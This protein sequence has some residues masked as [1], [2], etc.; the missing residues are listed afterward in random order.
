M[1][2]TPWVVAV[3]DSRRV[4]LTG[5]LWL[6]GAVLAGV[7]AWV[8]SLGASQAW[9]ASGA[10]FTAQT[11]GGPLVLPDGR[12]WEMVSPPEKGN[13]LI[14]GI[15]GFPGSTNGGLLQAAASGEAIVYASNGGFADSAGLPLE[16]QYLATRGVSGWSTVSITPRISSESYSPV[17]QGGPYK[18]FSSNLSSG[19]LLNGDLRPVRNPP[20]GGA[21]E[22]YQ[23]LYVQDIGTGDFHAVLTS[24]NPPSEPPEAFGLE[25]VGATPDLSHIVFST[26]AALTPNAIDSGS[27]NLYEWSNGQLQLVNV[28]PGAVLGE[29]LANSPGGLHPISNDGSV[30]FFSYEGDLYAHEN[31]KSGIQVDASSEGPESGGGQFQTAS[32]DGSRVF[33]TDRSRLTGNSTANRGEGFSDLYELDLG[34]GQLSDLTVGDPAGADVQRVLGAS[35]DGSYVYFVANGVLAQGASRGH[36]RVNIQGGGL[37]TCSLYVWHRDGG[38]GTTK[39]IATLSEDDNKEVSLDNAE[40]SGVAD[41][42]APSVANRTSRVTSDGLGLVFMSDGRLTGYDN[43]NPET[44]GR[45]QEVYVY[46]AGANAGAGALSCASCDPSGAQPSG[47]S[48]IPGGTQFKDVEAIYQSRVLSGVGGR[49]RVFFNSADALVPRDTNGK[50]DVYEWEEEGRGGCRGPGG[51]V[52]L[53][54]S[55]GSSGKSLFADASAD[56]SDVFFLTYSELVP[57]DTDQLLDVYDAREGGGFSGSSG[58]VP[59]GCEGESCKLPPSP[60]AALGALGSASYV[61]PGNV[62]VSGSKPAVKPRPRKVKPKKRG[63]KGRRRAK[64]SARR[65]GRA[66]W[67]TRGRV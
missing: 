12:A 42:W 58:V 66:K 44:G 24:A 38:T 3:A 9:G 63:G 48:D 14:T 62:S 67:S 53:I 13:S 17:G 49:M 10:S 54:S 52:G 35:E 6:I 30:V 2:G 34:S 8:A 29:N 28:L 1:D 19:L 40:N 50:Q 25:F 43:R 59:S 5:R 36:C 7:L 22:G 56:G 26:A 60:P 61:G 18:A 16:A 27:S 37:E 20:L 55:G 39:F 45:E 11:G 65:A 15:D 47:G 32:G 46:N 41:D 33:F 21:P 23:D 57:Q 64:R 51:C 31:G 4:V